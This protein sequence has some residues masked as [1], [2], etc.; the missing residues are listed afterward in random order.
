MN[1]YLPPEQY[2]VVCDAELCPEDI[3]E[4]GGTCDPCVQSELN[5]RGRECT[6]PDH[7]ARPMVTCGNPRSPHLKCGVCGGCY[8]CDRIA[9]YRNDTYLWMEVRKW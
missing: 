3:A 2:C 1:N 9:R 6:K 4:Y 5:A 7:I 8:R